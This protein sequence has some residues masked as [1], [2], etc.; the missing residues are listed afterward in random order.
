[1]KKIIV[2]YYGT[3]F[4]IKHNEYWPYPESDERWDDESKQRYLDIY[5]EH[6]ND[7]EWYLDEEGDRLSDHELFEKSPWTLIENGKKQKI[8][9]N[10]FSFETGQ[11]VVRRGKWENEWK[12]GVFTDVAFQDLPDLAELSTH[13][14]LALNTL[15]LDSSGI[16]MVNLSITSVTHEIKNNRLNVAFVGHIVVSSPINDS[17]LRC[18]WEIFDV[19]LAYV[20]VKHYDGSPFVLE[21]DLSKETSLSKVDFLKMVEQACNN[22]Q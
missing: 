6:Q 16:E 3:Q 5:K 18:G 7:S 21:K 2:E 15:R 19:V 12:F 14:K 9:V 8:L 1:M 10:H 22:L 20:L 17:T 4:V 11:G 13:Y